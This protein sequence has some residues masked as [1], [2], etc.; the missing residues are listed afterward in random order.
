MRKIRTASRPRQAIA[1]SLGIIWLWALPVRA[2]TFSPGTPPVEPCDRGDESPISDGGAWINQIDDGHLSTVICVGGIINRGATAGSGS[3]FRGNFGPDVQASYRYVD[4][5]GG[6][7]SVDIF[8][9]LSGASAA[10]R[11]GYACRVWGT[12]ANARWLLMR[13][14]DSNDVTLTDRNI[15]TDLT[16]PTVADNDVIGCE[17]IG[18]I[19][20]AYR[21]PGGINCEVVVTAVDTTYTNAGPVGIAFRSGNTYAV[22][23]FWAATVGAGGG[24]RFVGPIVFP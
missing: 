10:A 22:D 5:E 9:R 3:A 8:L 23:D 2:A 15:T 24:R 20:T 17:M 4:S 11:D 12:D 21:C 7:N 13:L 19:L 18:S 6:N 14:D 16:T 1:I